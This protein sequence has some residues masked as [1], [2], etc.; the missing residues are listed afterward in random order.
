MIHAE[1]LEWQ[2]WVVEVVG[3]LLAAAPFMLKQPR[4]EIFAEAIAEQ[5]NNN[6]GGNVS[7]L[8][9]RLHVSRRTIRDWVKGIQVPQID[10]LLRFCYLAHVS[11]LCLL[12]KDAAGVDPAG[13]GAMTSQEL[14]KKPKRHYKI[15]YG[16]QVR[17]ALE[18]ELLTENSPPRPMSA[19]AKHLN[20]DHSFLYKH[21]LYKHFPDLCH[22]ISVRYQA[23]R[24]KQSRKRHECFSTAKAHGTRTDHHHD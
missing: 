12:D 22:A 18:S 24:K 15:F 19:V 17:L 3:E 1:E 11:P 16:E 9:R 10:S 13:T 8:A 23:Y 14:K 20:Y 21:F 4:D 2:K 7:A 6:F 5:L